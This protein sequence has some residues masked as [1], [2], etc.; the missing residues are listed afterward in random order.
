MTW[1]CRIPVTGTYRH[2]PGC[3]AGMCTQSP[4]C[5]DTACPGH[6]GKGA[7]P[8]AHPAARNG[9]PRVDLSRV[10]L[11]ARP[12]AAPERG[13]VPAVL[14]ALVKSAVV[15]LALVGAVFTFAVLVE[16]AAVRA[17]EAVKVAT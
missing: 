15:A 13:L 16:V 17:A 1:N 3:S 8:A 9:A 5:A 10:Q 6:P 4:D 7:H 14:V 2:G 11:V 12:K